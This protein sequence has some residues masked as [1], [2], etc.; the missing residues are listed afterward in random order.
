MPQARQIKVRQGD[1]RQWIMH[2]QGIGKADQ[3]KVGE[4]KAEDHA[5]GEAEVRQ[6]ITPVAGPHSIKHLFQPRRNLGLET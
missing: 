4:C 2:R 3:S 5:T 6:K 1:L